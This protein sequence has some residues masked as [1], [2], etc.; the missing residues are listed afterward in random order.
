MYIENL[1]FYILKILEIQGPMI[2]IP[3]YRKN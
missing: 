1:N 2:F 3:E